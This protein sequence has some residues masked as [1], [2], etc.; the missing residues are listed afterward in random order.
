[1][2]V[3]RTKQ[4]SSFWQ[5]LRG[6]SGLKEKVGNWD[7]TYIN[8]HVKMEPK[9]KGFPKQML[10]WLSFLYENVREDNDGYSIKGFLGKTPVWVFSYDSVLN[11]L[12]GKRA[13]FG[14]PKQDGAIKLLCLGSYEYLSYHVAENIMSLGLESLDPLSNVANKLATRNNLLSDEE[15][16][17]NNLGKLIKNRFYK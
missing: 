10:S 5:R 12:S 11:Q 17:P 3:L 8:Q 1:M 7:P 4:F 15:R 9:F 16:D 2:L 14:I 6:N 13:G